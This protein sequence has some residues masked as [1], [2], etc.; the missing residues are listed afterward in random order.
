MT[1]DWTPLTASLHAKRTTNPIRKIVDQMKPTGPQSTKPMIALSIGDPTTD[2]NFLPPKSAID[3]IVA[4]VQSCKFNGYPPSVGYPA[5]RDA[6]AKYWINHFTPSL[7][8]AAAQIRGDRVILG[9]GASQ[10]ILMAI[11]A[12]CNE[13]DNILLPSPCFSL[14]GTICG[15]YGI[16][17]KHYKCDPS[18]NWECDLASIRALTDSRT[19]CLFL[20]NPSNPCGSNF[21]RSH[22]ADLLSLADELK[23]PVISDEI[24]SG[25]VFE[26]EVFTSVADF[27][28]NVPRIVIGGTAKNFIVPGWRLGWA[29]LVDKLN[30]A[31]D[32]FD[33]MVQLST[34]IVGPN[35]VVQSAL[36][37]ILNETEASYQSE[38]NKSL[39]RN[40]KTAYDIFSTCR[41]LR[42]TVP[43]GAMYMMVGLDM[44]MFK[45]ITSGIEFAK[46]LMA[47]ENVQVLPGEIFQMPNFFR[48]V[49]TKPTELVGEAAKR[50]EAFCARHSN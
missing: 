27:D 44:S 42:P 38:L 30:I 32:V 16:D 12:L 1:S 18:N 49:Y 29:I 4:N 47:E 31:A 39:Y 11:T 23:L 2:G 21:R 50:I 28:S 46:M 13:G 40:A 15:S 6:V 8:D 43:Q 20:N 22:V 24:Y 26:D 41:G 19:K 3:A 34:L 7:P 45:D 17:V 33:G 36:D 35:S 9:S 14:Y 48:V 5:S 25:M 10:A 37:K